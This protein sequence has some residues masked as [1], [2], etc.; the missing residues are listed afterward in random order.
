[1]HV[2]GLHDSAVLC[3]LLYEVYEEETPIMVDAYG[4]EKRD[5]FL[6]EVAVVWLSCS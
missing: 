6:A 3:V 1:M 2:I 4:V 5:P